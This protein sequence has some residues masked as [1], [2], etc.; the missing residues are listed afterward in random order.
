[1]FFSASNR[2]DGSK[3]GDD[4]QVKE[5]AEEAALVE[6]VEDILNT[7]GVQFLKNASLYFQFWDVRQIC[8]MFMI[9]VPFS[10]CRLSLF[11]KIGR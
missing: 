11:P 1:M 5:K 9:I 8:P 3:S 6:K 10:Q 7:G 2:D 4:P